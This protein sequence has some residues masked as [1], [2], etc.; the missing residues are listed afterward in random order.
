FILVAVFIASLWAPF[1]DRFPTLWEYFQ[2]ALS[3][4]SPPVVSCFLFGLFWKR[5]S[6]GAAFSTLWMDSLA[7]L[8]L[9]INNYFDSLIEPVHYLYS[10]TIIF[11]IIS[12]VMV[13][14]SLLYAD[15]SFIKSRD[16][17]DRKMLRNESTRWY[18]SYQ[19]FALIVFLCC[20]AVVITFW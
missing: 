1:I 9:I 10:A 6:A 16:S 2:A 14:G 17:W 4:L 12:V 15:D 20:A 13:I 8:L 5:A 18:S 11:M 3:Y 7:V 19:F